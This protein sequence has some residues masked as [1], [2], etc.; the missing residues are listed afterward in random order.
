MKMCRECRDAERHTPATVIV[1]GVRTLE[2]GRKVPYSGPLCD[3]HCEFV[4]HDD[5]EIRTITPL[6][7]NQ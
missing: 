5:T 7:G 1:Q 6:E 3:D 4:Q 2:N